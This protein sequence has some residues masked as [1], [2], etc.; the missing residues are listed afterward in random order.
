MY[1]IK[2][3]IASFGAKD[4]ER[5]LRGCTL[6][7]SSYLLQPLHARIHFIPSMNCQDKNGFHYQHVYLQ[8]ARTILSRSL[9]RS[10]FVSW[11][12]GV[13]ECSFDMDQDS[14]TRLNYVEFTAHCP[15]ELIIGYKRM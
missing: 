5:M 1:I 15:V 13:V 4:V 14:D 7:L 2:L 10:R 8:I 3:R 12:R 9:Q 6:S 11:L